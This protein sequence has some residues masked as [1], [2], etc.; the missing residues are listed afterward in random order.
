MDVVSDVM[1]MIPQKTK[2]KMMGKLGRAIRR[3]VG[4]LFGKGAMRFMKNP[5]KMMG[6]GLSKVLGK[7]R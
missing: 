2:A 3:P 6:K 7:G 1:D 5:G 4:K